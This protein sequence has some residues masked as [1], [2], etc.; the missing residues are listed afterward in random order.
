[1]LK[2][3]SLKKS[4]TATVLAVG[5][6]LVG[7]SSVLAGSQISNNNLKQAEELGIDT[8]GK[9]VEEINVEIEAITDAAR[10]NAAAVTA[11]AAD[12]EAATL[13]Q[14]KELD[15]DTNGKTVEEIN[16]E[17]E[18]ITDAARK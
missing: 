6:G 10:A 8:N 12:K 13:K 7:V 9:T 18:A 15:I 1:M 4:V 16:V 14:A 3:P 2:K 11:V 17:I 5:I